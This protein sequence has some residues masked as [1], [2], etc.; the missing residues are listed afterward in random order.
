MYN[1]RKEKDMNKKRNTMMRG[2]MVLAL[3]GLLAMV[4]GQDAEARGRKAEC[5][6]YTRTLYYADGHSRSTT[7]TACLRRDGNWYV[8][9]EDGN[10]TMIGTRLAVRGDDRRHGTRRDYR[11]PVHEQVRFIA[12][13]D[14][15]HDS[16][17]HAP[18]GRN[19]AT[20]WG[21]PDRW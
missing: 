16:R 14:R 18:H 15:Q 9:G 12:W 7:G 4:P 17:A 21:Y 6:E 8:V 1:N 2:G 5:R 19:A 20:G 11:H 10:R 3:A 13:P